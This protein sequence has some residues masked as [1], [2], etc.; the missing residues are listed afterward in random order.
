MERKSTF[1]AH[2]Y[3]N[4]IFFI[5]LNTKHFANIAFLYNLQRVIA[6][7]GR[8]SS[9]TSKQH[10]A[11]IS[12]ILNWESAWQNALIGWHAY[13]LPNWVLLTQVASFLHDVISM[14]PCKMPHKIT[15]IMLRFMIKYVLEVR[16]IFSKDTF[17]HSLLPVP[18][19]LM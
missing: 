1:R 15:K 4:R 16:M 14:I 3:C 13:R 17:G 2:A 10:Q 7:V 5:C 6:S 9:E 19:L 18:V 8:Y 12:P 11:Q